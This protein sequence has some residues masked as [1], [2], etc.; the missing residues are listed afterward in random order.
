MFAGPV[1]FCMPRLLCKNVMMAAIN[2][3]QHPLGAGM[4]SSIPVWC[5]VTEDLRKRALLK[6]PS[7]TLMIG[8][9]NAGKPKKQP[10]F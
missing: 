1:P 7:L 9:K 6:W 8:K 5:D 2:H 4:S 3:G 10:P